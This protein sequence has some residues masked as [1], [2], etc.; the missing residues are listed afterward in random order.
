MMMKMMILT[1]IESQLSVNYGKDDNDFI[2][3]FYC[4]KPDVLC[5]HFSCCLQQLNVPIFLYLNH[6]RVA[7]GNPVLFTLSPP[8]CYMEIRHGYGT[9]GARVGGP[10]RVGDPLTLIIYM[11]SKYGE[12][13]QSGCSGAFYICLPQLDSLFINI[14]KC[15]ILYIQFL[16]LQ[17]KLSHLLHSR[18]VNTDF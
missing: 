15:I 6:C 9:S 2:F 17:Q 13:S 4:T 14:V 3:N 18:L 8:E 1:M 10:V 12:F 11:R 5:V 16:S 7:T